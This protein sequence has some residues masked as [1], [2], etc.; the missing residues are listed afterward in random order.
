MSLAR[1]LLT[2]LNR[3][4]AQ[5]VYGGTLARYGILNQ[6]HIGSG[7]RV[8]DCSVVASQWWLSGGVAAANCVAAYQ[9]KG[10]ASLA[11]SYVN[12]AN[13]GTNNA[14]PGVA[15]TFN[16]ET[17]WTF[18]GTTQYLRT[19]LIPANDQSWSMLIRYSDMAG[20][21][22]SVM[23]EADW[24]ARGS[25]GFNIRP[26]DWLCFV[27]NGGEGYITI[28]STGG[29]LGVA[30]NRGYYNG[31]QDSDVI[32][33]WNTTSSYEIPI[34][35][36]NRFGVFGAYCGT[37]IQAMAVYSATLTAPQV[38]AISAAMAAL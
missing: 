9:A 11:A 30:G 37:K 12:L 6:L 7:V 20:S 22:L 26:S 25:F 38:A 35:C 8:V 28:S 32:L 10:A 14:A 34:G 5:Q 33:G 24:P 31:T 16:A 23:Y 4:N 3:S 21:S 13:P 15:P 27:N 2:L 36:R 19:G 18:N 17:G 1:N 29:V